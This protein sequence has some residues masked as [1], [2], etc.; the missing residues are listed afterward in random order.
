MQCVLF[1]LEALSFAF[2]ATSSIAHENLAAQRRPCV[3]PSSFERRAWRRHVGDRQVE[4]PH[5]SGSHCGTHILHPQCDQLA[6]LNEGHDRDRAPL[7]YSVKVHSKVA[8]SR[9]RHRGCLPLAR[10]EADTDAAQT[11]TPCYGRYLQGMGVAR[12]RC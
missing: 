10:A 8:R 12:A 9:A 2:P 4:P 6:G 3:L 1:W 5:P 7:G 11:L